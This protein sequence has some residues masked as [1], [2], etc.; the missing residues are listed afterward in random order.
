MEQLDAQDLTLYLAYQHVKSLGLKNLKTQIF[1]LGVKAG[2]DLE[3]VDCQTS[4]Q[5]VVNKYNS[6]ERKTETQVIDEHTN[7]L[8]YSYLN[9]ANFTEVAEEFGKICRI[10]KELP[11]RS[12]FSFIY[13]FI[14]VCSYYSVLIALDSY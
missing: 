7:Q 10:P 8:V 6:S 4:V 13:P 5:D 14:Q 2:L 12:L 3:S 11:E 1:N 9:R